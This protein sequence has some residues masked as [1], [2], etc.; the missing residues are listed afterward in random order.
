M[1]VDP[2]PQQLQAGL[3]E[4]GVSASA[5]QLL[6][7]QQ[8]LALLFKWNKTHNLTAIDNPQ[9]AVKLHVLDSISVLPHI[10]GPRVLDVGSGAGLPGILLAIMRPHIEFVSVDARNKK[11]HFQHLAA[12]QLG[13]QNFRAEHARIEDFRSAQP[14][15]QII[16][17][18]FSS[19]LKFTTLTQHVLAGD[20]EWIAM[21]G[22]YPEDELTELDPGKVRLADT[23]TLVIPGSQV[24][25]HAVCLRLATA[26]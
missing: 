17:R 21:K 5:D 19:L 7:I 2:I 3:Q 25:R 16:A 18:A 14:F 15:D 6:A 8:Y 13:L 23:H 22:Q 26:N 12:A 1:S 4:L 11:I 24:R 10:N 9:Q 20:G